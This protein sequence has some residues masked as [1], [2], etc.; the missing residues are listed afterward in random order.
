M[1]TILY[2]F[3]SALSAF[4]APGD[5]VFT[6]SGAGGNTPVL[7]TPVNGRVLYWNGTTLG[8]LD[9]ASTYQ[10]LTANLTSWAAIAPATK[11][12]LNSP[13]FTGTPRTASGSTFT[14]QSGSTFESASGSTI[15]IGN[16]SA[17]RTSLGLVI[18]TDVLAPNGV[19]T[20]LTG[21]GAFNTTGN[22]ATATSAGSLALSGGSTILNG[23]TNTT[24]IR[25]GTGNQTLNV[26]TSYTDAS[27]Y[28]GV[29]IL[30]NWF[31]SH[32]LIT[33]RGAGTGLNKNLYIGTYG[34]GDLGFVTNQNERWRIS[35]SGHMTSVGAM[36]LTVGGTLAV[37]G[38]S[39]L[40]AVNSAGI[41]RSTAGFQLVAYTVGTLPSAG[42]YPYLE[43]VVED[44][45]A[46]TVGSTVAAGGSARAKVMS[47][48]TN[49]I[50]TATL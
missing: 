48:G 40:A 14:I 45:L 16:Q 37:T 5:Y 43:C 10:P 19:V 35:S 21:T 38:T 15:T 28:S 26:Y 31:S 11:A 27:N 39:T 36:N 23:G 30:T 6:K 7:L 47:N 49:W 8:N 12:D 3:L 9:I 24:D 22:A 32:P 4:A 44:S 1:K 34:G 29:Q 13:I 33:A 46:P 25:N 42:T 18:G 41:V 20:N 50:V 17:W 2:L